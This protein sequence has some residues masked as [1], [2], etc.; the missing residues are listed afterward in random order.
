MRLFP[1]PAIAAA[2]DACA[3]IAFAVIGLLSHRGG[4]SGTGLARDA[5]PLLA[6]WFAAGLLVRLYRRP[7]PTRLAATWLGGVT[8]GVAGRALVLGRTADRH[9]AAFLAVSLSFSLVF[10]LG[11]RL[12]ATLP[13]AARA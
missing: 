8:A 1:R 12:L 6:G 4:V 10:V 13:P 5:L 9:E 3:L 7:S 11:A 2:C